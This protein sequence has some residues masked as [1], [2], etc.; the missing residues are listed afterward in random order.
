M[1]YKWASKTGSKDTRVETYNRNIA[2]N[3]FVFASVCHLFS[4]NYVLLYL[5]I[6]IYIH[7]CCHIEYAG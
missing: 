7:F 4:L 5:Y 1:V 2:N 3:R 6:V